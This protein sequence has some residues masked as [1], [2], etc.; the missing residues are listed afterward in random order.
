MRLLNTSTLEM[1]YFDGG[2]TTPR[3]PPYSILSHTWNEG[4]VTLQEMES[5]PTSCL[6]LE[7]PGYSNV[8]ACVA[9]ARSDGYKY[10]WIDTCW[11]VAYLARYL[12]L[13]LPYKLFSSVGVC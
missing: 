4:E 3:C 5:R 12:S 6:V 2:P 13:N 11:C 9:K 7:K 10:V 8:L 1:E